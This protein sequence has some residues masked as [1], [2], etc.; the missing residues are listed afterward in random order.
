MTKA[1]GQSVRIDL[2][3]LVENEISR[4]QHEVNLLNAQR[5]KV[6]GSVDE[7]QALFKKLQADIAAAQSEIVALSEEKQRVTAELLDV[8]KRT[9]ADIEKRE[10]QA[11]DRINEADSR[12]KE[13]DRQESKVRQLLGVLESQ[14]SDFRAL[15]ASVCT[16]L[17]DVSAEV[18]R[19][20]A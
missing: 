17:N 4:A 8:R 2:G 1:A 10:Y 16:K 11:Q 9:V 6:Q 19:R 20:C 15:V 7:A 18:E 5:A 13:A 14:R 12:I 3:A